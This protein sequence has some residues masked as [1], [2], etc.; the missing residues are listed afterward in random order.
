[1]KPVLELLKNRNSTAYQVDPSVSV[2]EALRLLADHG[3]GAMLVMDK[4]KLVGV[5]SE[6]DYTR[7]VALQGKNSRETKVA[8]IMTSDVITVTPETGT[9]ACMTLMSQKKIRHLPVVDGSKVI[10][11]ISIRDIMDDIIADH[12]QTISQLTSYINS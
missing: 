12:E 7:K 5:V 1:M 9:R 3:V 4:G 8:D 2:F 6:R 10:G 11:M